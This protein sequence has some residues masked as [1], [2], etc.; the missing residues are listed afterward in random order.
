MREANQETPLDI[1]RRVVGGGALRDRTNVRPFHWRVC[2]LRPGVVEVPRFTCR[3]KDISFEIESS[4]F[5]VREASQPGAMPF[6][7]PKTP[8]IVA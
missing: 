4:T 5:L 2:K 7:L 6:V 1:E 3:I 8:P